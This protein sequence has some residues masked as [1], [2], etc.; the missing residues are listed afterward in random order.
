MGCLREQTRRALH[1]AGTLSPVRS[2][3]TAPR[4]PPGAGSV[5]RLPSGR[6]QA[7]VY[8]AD[9]R[10]KSLGSYARKADA[11]AAAIAGAARAALGTEDDD[12]DEPQTVGE[13][14]ERWLD[15]GGRRWQP[16]TLRDYR[17]LVDC[18]VLPRWGQLP[19][20][21]VTRAAVVAW[22]G[23]LRDTGLSVARVRHA[24]GTLARILRH[25]VELG[26]LDASP[27]ERLRLPSP[28]PAS[29]RPLSVEEVERLADAIAHPVYPAAGH[30]AGP[31]PRRLHRPDLALWVRLA[32]YCGLRAGE[33]LALRRR[34]VDLERCVV[35]VDRSVVSVSGRL[36]LGPTKTGRTRAV[37]V[38]AALA[39][40]LVEHLGSRVGREP[41]ALVF[42]SEAGGLVDHGAW[43]KAHLKPAAARAGLPA[44]LRYHDLR[45]TYASLLIAQ[46]AHPRAIMERLGHS[47]ITV[48][49]G[50]YGHLFPSLDEALTARL[51]EA[52][53]AARSVP[54]A[55]G[56]GRAHGARMGHGGKAVAPTTGGE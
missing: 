12:Q 39:D 51:S 8:L 16:T 28:R 34:S 33:V 11:Q 53:S 43:Y 3:G 55:R 52:I 9:G 47:S 4:R 6:W 30:G 13:W 46:G 25:A 21:S 56:T 42:T 40:Q 23:E 18:R 44:R 15:D 24:V 7:R 27:A 1:N 49:L 32:A 38:P 54:R 17:S 37:P 41:D 48:T 19:A 20:S 29:V 22:A 35:V 10:R 36:V 45:H 50:T 2:A 14:A 31:P 5:R 26:G